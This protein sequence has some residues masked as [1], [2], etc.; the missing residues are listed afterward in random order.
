[1]RQLSVWSAL[2]LPMGFLWLISF[3][4]LPKAA[5]ASH[6]IGGDVSM[7][8][9]GGEPGLFRLQLNQYWDEK[10]TGKDTRDASVRL[11]IY[12]KNNPVFVEAITLKLQETLPLEFAN[13]ACAEFRELEFTEARYYDVVQFDPQKYTDPGGY[14]IVWERCCRNDDLTNTNSA[15]AA[16]VGMVFYLEF[17]PMV[18]GGRPFV[19]SSPD[20]KL[21]NGDYICLNKPFTYDV[22]A[23][24]ADG[25]LLLYTIVQPFNGY[26]T[27]SVPFSVSDAPRASYPPIT[28][29]RGYSLANVIPGNPPLNINTTTGIVN[30]RAN[31]E[32]LF[33]FTVQCEEYRN[34]QRIGVVRRDIQL[35][36]VDCSKNTP[37]P[38]I[39][40]VNNR[41][42]SG[43]LVWCGSQPLVFRVDKNENYRYQWQ[44]DGVNITGANADTLDVKIVGKYTVVTSQAKICANDT[45]SKQVTVSFVTPPTVKLRLEGTKPFCSGDTIVLQAEGQPGYQYQW[46]RNGTVLAAQETASLRV[47][48]SGRYEVLA[49]PG[50]A[51]CEGLDSLSLTFFPR[52]EARISAARPDL[53]PGDSVLLTATNQPGSRFDWRRDGTPFGDTINRVQTRLGGTFRVKVTNPSGCSAES[54][55]LT[56]RQNEQPT[57]LL[58]SIPPLCGSP[59][60]VVTLNGQPVGGVYSGPGVN[61]NRFDPTQAGT[62]RHP[63]TYRVTSAQGCRAEQ[64]R[65]AVV[66]PGPRVTGPPSYILFKGNSVQIKTQ[67]TEEIGQYIW[68]PPV[69]LSRPDVPNPIASPLVTTPY[70]LTAISTVGCPTSFSIV[71]EV[72]EPMYIPS[73]FSPNGD[74]LN[75]V[76]VIPNAGQFPN[77]DVAVYNRWGEVVFQSKGYTIPWDG[78][79]RQERVSP[80]VYT[81]RINTGEGPYSTTY[82][83]QLT[84][85]Y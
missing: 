55:L 22:S 32:G 37:T 14:Y 68:S 84:V 30:V 50:A 56:I 9:Q 20:F 62:G 41:P 79:S 78:T 72:V 6:I 63:I 21:P 67:A 18:R 35:P 58:D 64:T 59:E 15:I 5:E 74:G 29:N 7:Q 51:V 70:Q 31:R 10:Q 82:R 76:W 43:D 69:S 80:G 16:G 3:F 66:S 47:T 11:L 12:R 8:Q 46:R 36:V 65:I 49:R 24:D 28:W 25:D 60:S 23:T 42:V 45:V 4:L 83:G 33:L 71:V 52:P 17:P 19:N 38:A 39:I 27:R 40:S 34:G 44:R 13:S 54:A 1:M 2:R 61:G 48:Q 75:D 73:A 77:C 85:I 81:Y 57:A 53:C 26:T